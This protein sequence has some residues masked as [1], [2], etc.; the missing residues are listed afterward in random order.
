MSNRPA[1]TNTLPAWIHVWDDLRIGYYPSG[2][3]G[4]GERKVVRGGKTWSDAERRVR[5]IVAEVEAGMSLKIDRDATWHTLCAAW[6]AQHANNMPEGTFRARLSVINSYIVPAI[7]NVRLVETDSTTLDAILDAYLAGGSGVSRFK[8]VVQTVRTI[9]SWAR[10]KK[11]VVADCFGPE[12]DER[13]AIS[14]AHATIITRKG[15]VDSEETELTMTDVPSKADVELLAKA[16]KKVVESRTGIKGSGTRYARAIRVAAGTGLRMCELLGL[17]VDDIDLESGFVT[18]DHQLDRYVSWLP[19][20]P[21]P[22]APPK[23][24][25]TRKARAWK[26][27]EDDLRALINSAGADGV[28]LPPINGATW[29]ADQWGHILNEAMADCGWKWAPHYLRHHYGS[30][31][32]APRAK[33][34]KGM[35]YPTVQKSLGHSSLKT[36][37]STYIHSTASDEKG[38][39]E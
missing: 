19:G 11:W 3:K 33:G 37:L 28:L 2:S 31:S 32:T 10:R 29:W 6:V 7:G 38:W 26:S 4:T 20:E 9:K 1:W 22:T 17:T 12:S 8:T 27:V 24:R 23:G 5:Q 18:V 21:M 25:R 15:I 14:A 35:D 16:V 30:F 13:A 39:V 34:G 36:T